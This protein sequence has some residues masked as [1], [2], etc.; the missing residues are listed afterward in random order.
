MNKNQTFIFN[1]NIVHKSKYDYSLV[2]YKKNNIKVKIICPI[3]GEFEQRPN[4]HL[5]GYGCSRCSNKL[6]YTTESFS[7]YA[8]ELHQNRYK[9]SLVQY[10]NSHTKVKIICPIHGVFEQT[11]NL[12]L[13]QKCGCPKCNMSKGE[14]QI[15]KFLNSTHI[16]FQT[17][18]KFENCKNK[19]LLP[20]D[21]YLPELNICIEFD[22]EH[23]FS[24]SRR[25]KNNEVNKKH[26]NSTKICD[27]IKNNFCVDRGIILIRIPHWD[28]ANLHKYLTF[29]SP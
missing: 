2:D 25:S 20:F 7:S 24:Q 11:P 15:F 21:F 28:I 27:T 19:K 10:I 9:Y 18:Y 8:S 4:D 6:K 26:F 12:H 23:H 13:S 14:L 22:G 16:K 5:K 29:S 1:S 17:Q 3:H